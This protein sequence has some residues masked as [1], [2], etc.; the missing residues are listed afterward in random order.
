[1]AV[2]QAEVEALLSDATKRIEGDIT[3]QADEDH[4]HCVDFRAEVRSD[5][6]WPLFVRGSFN[7]LIPALS[8]NLILKSEGRV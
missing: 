6:G 8:Y 7:P 3:W 5:T 1:M 2:S 4:S